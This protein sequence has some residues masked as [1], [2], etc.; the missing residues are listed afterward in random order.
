MQAAV[1]SYDEGGGSSSSGGAHLA[2]AAG[3]EHA[4]DMPEPVLVPTPA[5]D[6]PAGALEPPPSDVLPPP[7]PHP[8]T[9]EVRLK[10][11][12]CSRRHLY[13]EAFA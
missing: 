9:A 8:E 2:P 3:D 6:Q 5:V 4:G 7:A 10:R 12:A 1:R 11:E 13:N